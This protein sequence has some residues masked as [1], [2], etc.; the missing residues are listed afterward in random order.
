MAEVV[1]E[2]AEAE[3]EADEEEDIAFAFAGFRLL[4]DAG[5]LRTHRS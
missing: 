1:E 4:S 3:A 5:F 2:E